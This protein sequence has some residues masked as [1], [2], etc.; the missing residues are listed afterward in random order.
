MNPQH[1]ERIPLPA[2]PDVLP[3]ATPPL[4]AVVAPLAV[5]VVLWV[6]T[7]SPYALLVGLVGPLVALGT[8]VEGRRSARRARRRSLAEARV[9]LRDLER[10]LEERM[11]RSRAELAA[12]TPPLGA[13]ASDARIA[14]MIGLGTVD[15][16]IRLTGDVAPELAAEVDRLREGLA[17]EGAPVIVDGREVQVVGTPTLVRAFSRVLVLQAV[18]RCGPGR[19]RVTAPPEEAWARALPATLVE[20][21]AWLVADG[22]SPV[23]RL[24]HGGEGSSAP[25]VDLGA[26]G[27]PPTA[28]GVRDWRPALLAAVEAERLAARLADQARANG[29]SDAGDL[30]HE[31]SLQ[32]LLVHQHAT[33]PSAACIGVGVGGPVAV[34]LES[35]GPHALVAGTTGS[36][37]SELLVTWVLAL[38]ARRPPGELG[39][40]LIDFKGGAAF[41]P[42]LALPHVVGVVSDLDESTA[43]R[44]VLSLRAELRR[45]EAVLAEHRLRDVDELPPGTMARLVVVVDEF[46]AL[47]GSDAES[48]HV[49]SDLAARGRSLGIH[50]VLGTQRPAGVVR[51]ALLANVTVR[52]C[53]RVLDA[54]ES[55][56]VIGAPD[57]AT[58]PSSARGRGIVS[59]GTGR[60]T[61]QVARA[62]PGLVAQVADR[63]RG[64]EVPDARPWVDPLPARIP[65]E[66]VR[67]TP[68]VVGLVDRPELQRREPLV[69]DPWRGAVLILGGTGSGRTS[70]LQTLAAASDAEVRW[71]GQQPAELWQAIATPASG[72]LLVAIDDL[73]ALLARGDP[74]TRAELGELLVRAARDGRHGGLA[75]AA[76][77]RSAGA[78]LLSA[79]AVFEQRVLLRMP[80]REEHLLAGG[81]ARAYRADR[82]PGAACWNGHEAQFALPPH[83]RSEWRA[84]LEEVHPLGGSWGVVSPRPAE[85]LDRLAAQSV[86]TA[87]LGIDVPTAD[88]VL[89][90]DPETWLATHHDLARLRREGRLLLHGCTRADHRTLTRAR[91]GLPP[92]A[93]DDEAWLVEARVTRRVR[94]A[95]P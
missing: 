2:V 61:M 10:E 67:R 32:A 6:V 12:S 64:Y 89:I 68:G 11:R 55:T 85:W 71:I 79:A 45:R 91:D 87:A 59:D 82:R 58:I 1:P 20:G 3:R 26:E 42:L 39:F 52:V 21:S 7:S 95:A 50:L 44:A 63:W 62:D 34:D 15:P 30:P 81:E 53:L 66:E 90:A 77:A 33:R 24:R 36:G 78:S 60:R 8:A 54:A 29:W 25:C 14:W 9:E 18:A 41:D 48:Q 86:A 31:V 23:L 94:V 46:A 51:D 47:L 76:S 16:G 40:L 73:D 88:A 22:D 70:A 74:E 27:A 5:A 92:L 38:A 83:A 75:I 49:F 35:D 17:L 4:V 72:R 37:K 13:L 57:A 43:A 28:P 69:L 93:S 84:A 65:F 80:S 56:S 19:A